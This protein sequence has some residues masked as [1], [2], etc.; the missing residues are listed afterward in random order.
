MKIFKFVKE[1][2]I[3]FLILI[4]CSIALISDLIN[5]YRLLKRSQK[6]KLS[7]GISNRIDSIEN[8]K[9]SIII[10]IKNESKVIGKTLR[11]LEATVKDKSNCEVILV[12]AGC[13]DNSI[14]VAKASSCCIPLL[15]I[16]HL[17]GIGRGSSLNAGSQSASGEI[18][19]FLRSD[20]L[21]PNEFDVILRQELRKPE[22]LL[23]AFTFGIDKIATNYSK[24]I[25]IW[26]YEYYINIRSRYCN[27][28]GG[29]QAFAMYKSSF[30][31]R[32]FK[33]KMIM[34]DI[35]FI[36]RIRE[37]TAS[38]FL[39]NANIINHILLFI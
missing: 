23:T 12:D 29:Y 9:I 14:D 19:V 25:G 36:E 15:I 31:E 39:Q 34:E 28:P 16:K 21:L 6:S 37:E 22:V 20:C 13:T 10:A 11:N 2:I 7:H 26:I 33:D 3:E 24:L 5:V 8:P 32:Q 1:K 35:E 4:I 17:N 38:K 27:L 18:I 30:N